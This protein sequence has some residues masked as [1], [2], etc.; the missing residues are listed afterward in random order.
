MSK[1]LNNILKIALV[2]SLILVVTS[3]FNFYNSFTTAPT[4]SPLNIINPN[5]ILEV[6]DGDNLA[7]IGDKLQKEKV[8]NYGLSLPILAQTKEKWVLLPNKYILNLPASP[9][10]ILDQ[11]KDQS[12]ALAKKPK[13][14]EI[15]SVTITIKEGNTTDDIINL[16]VKNNISNQKDLEKEINNY[17]FFQSKYDFL[18]KE[19]NCEYGKIKNCAKYYLEGY[20]YPDTYTFFVNSTNQNTAKES[21]GKLLDNFNTKVWSKVKNNPKY[22]SPSSFKNEFSKA[23]IMAS[24]IEKETGRPINGVNSENIAELSKEKQIM[25]GAFYNRLKNNQLWQS[26]PTVSYGTGKSL[27][28][29]TLKT[30]TDCLYL[31]SPEVDTLYNT[32]NQIGY[33]I[34]PIT[35]P[36]ITS[37]E[38]SLTPTDN[39]YLFF[40]SDASGKKYFAKNNDEHETN[41]SKVQEINKQYRN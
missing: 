19:L 10:Q 13:T 35:S 34:A 4:N 17:S 16:L 30:L 5:Y 36:T 18:P 26:D 27:C 9:T 31:D 3:I 21:L 41:I 32:Y 40:V 11:L 25:A 33:P 20:L 8:L 37:I 28:Q 6:K 2:I 24:V 39:D 22:T 23:V 38:A 29:R 12:V 15:P 14:K 1:I 7:V